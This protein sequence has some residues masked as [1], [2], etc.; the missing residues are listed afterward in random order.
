MRNF[1]AI[2]EDM[3]AHGMKLPYDRVR[4][5][6]KGANEALREGM[7]YILRQQGRETIWLPEYE[8]VS[9]WLS[10]NEGRGLMLMGG[11]GLGKTILGMYVLP[12]LILHSTRLV[13]RCYTAQEMNER[14]DEVVAKRIVS[15]DDVGTEEISIKYGE[16]RNV[17]AEVMDNAEKKGNLVIATTNLNGD[18]LRQR[19]G[20]RVIDRIRSTMRV[21]PLNGNSMRK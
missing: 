19:Y 9:N 21:I 13:T 4:I 12:G 7:D 14:P 10:D 1:E 8:R 5:R 16:R 2:Y 11:C 20:D 3:K 6:L 17:F 15:L 18:G